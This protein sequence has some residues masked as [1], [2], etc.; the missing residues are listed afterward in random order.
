MEDF[1]VKLLNMG[2]FDVT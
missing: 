2:V 1:I